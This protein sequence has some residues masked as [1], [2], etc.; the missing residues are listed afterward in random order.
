MQDQYRI[1]DP[2][3]VCLSEYPSTYFFSL[4][5]QS[6]NQPITLS[7]NRSEPNSHQSIQNH[8]IPHPFFSPPPPPWCPFNDIFV[9][10]RCC[11]TYT[12][13]RGF[14][15]YSICKF[16]SILYPYV[17]KTRALEKE[18]KKKTNTDCFFSFFFL[19]IQRCNKAD[20]MCQGWN[21]DGELVRRSKC[22]KVS[23]FFLVFFF[24]LLLSFFFCSN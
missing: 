14:E 16:I 4:T 10:S 23:F 1:S 3:L 6:I 12:C 5:N 22:Y 15:N 17:P 24:F 2:F 20:G 21:Q 8:A 11:Y 19:R 18:E 13:E 9:C 7:L